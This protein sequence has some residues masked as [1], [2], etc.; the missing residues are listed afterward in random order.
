MARG[1]TSAMDSALS[2][3]E[4]KPFF[5]V[6]L[7]FS[8]PVYLWSGTY[9]LSHDSK[10][11]LGTG[12]LMTVEIPQE[13]QDIGAVGVRMQLSGLTGTNILT[14]ALQQE[15]QGKSVTIKLGAFNTSGNVVADPVVV[16]EGFMDVMQITE[17]GNTSTIT[18]SVENKLIRLESANHRRYTDADQKIDH[19]SDS[20]FEFVT[21]IQEKQIKWGL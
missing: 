8:S 18:L 12:D 20:G 15:Y 11:Y 14:A 10:S 7:M 1:I 9:T 4:V 21:D 3:S 6:D 17:D 13:T 5:L 19:P 2:A 16:F